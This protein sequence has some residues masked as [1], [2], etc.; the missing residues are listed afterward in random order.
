MNG[1]QQHIIIKSK[2][3]VKAYNTDGFALKTQISKLMS[4]EVLLKINNLFD[5]LVRE[6]EWLLIDKLDIS[7]GEIQAD[8][9]ESIF[10]RKLIRELEEQIIRKKQSIQSFKEIHLTGDNLISLE[11][12]IVQLFIY[13]LKNGNVP[14]PGISINELTEENIISALNQE[15]E[16][17]SELLFLSDGENYS[18]W[19][20][21]LKSQFSVSFIRHF[22]NLILDLKQS[23]KIETNFKAKLEFI[24]TDLI[25]W[26][27]LLNINNIAPGGT[28]EPNFEDSSSVIKELSVADKK[29]DSGEADEEIILSTEELFRSFIN[30]LEGK[31]V[32]IKIIDQI[33]ENENKL[34]AIITQQPL[35]FTAFLVGI[36]GRNEEIKKRFEITFSKKFKES[37]LTIVLKSLI[38]TPKKI[39]DSI[40]KIGKTGIKNLNDLITVFNSLDE[41]SKKYFE[42]ITSKQKFTFEGKDASILEEEVTPA[43]KKIKSEPEK[44]KKSENEIFV[45]NVG[46][47]LLNPF[48]V[49]FFNQFDLLDDESKFKDKASQILAIYLLHYL[50][51][52]EE[53]A[54]EYS[55]TFEK[56]LC[57]YPLHMT[58]ERFIH[59]TDEMK[60]E[61][62]NLLKATVEH[63]K[64][65]KSTSPDGLREAFLQ[66]NG[67]LILNDTEHKIIVEQNSID[68]LLEH[69]PWSCSIIQLPWMKQMLH[70]EWIKN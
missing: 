54:F 51:T 37:I 50:A 39:K 43:I 42:E 30:F 10:S 64:I 56:Y 13:F 1:T 62:E 28:T 32:S 24:S 52:K 46:L 65:L 66:R 20:T 3:E 41:D 40:L 18:D 12:R 21:R 49:N 6:D 58:I 9:L 16:Y 26:L 61:S 60:N 44:D 2:L 68:L 36:A 7:L 11:K 25:Q 38:K 47:V 5:S 45:N 59:M 22:L 34:I 23:L 8:K 55:L 70:V 27:K 48:L 35:V 67:K 53:N 57:G 33:R 31:P 17:L 69:L 63:W 14:L 4:D 19:E 15:T 29:Y